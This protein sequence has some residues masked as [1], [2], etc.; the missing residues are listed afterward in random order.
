MFEKENGRKI[1]FVGDNRKVPTKIVSTMTAMKY[2]RK[3]YD[4]YLAFVINKRKEE[5]ELKKVP[6]VN[7]FRDVF[8]KKLP[9]LPF[10]REIEFE[11]ELLPGTSPI[12]Q[13]LYRMAPVELKEL[14]VQL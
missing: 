5:K 3:G 12:S 11:I 8:P 9:G 6:I 13:A 2:L 4:V 14:N 7:E 10:E 1:C